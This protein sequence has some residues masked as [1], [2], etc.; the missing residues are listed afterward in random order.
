[1]D[2]APTPLPAS[3]VPRDDEAATLAARSWLVSAWREAFPI[4]PEGA[5]AI[6]WGQSTIVL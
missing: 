5:R 1:M 3:H 6:R 2:P 4:P